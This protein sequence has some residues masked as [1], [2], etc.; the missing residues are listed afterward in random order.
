MET[1]KLK[2]LIEKAKQADRL[3]AGLFAQAVQA[4][5]AAFPDENF[6][7]AEHL[8]AEDPTEAVLHLVSEHL[9][10]WTISLKG[11]AQDVNGDWSCILRRSD[12][13]DNEVS[14]GVGSGRTLSLAVLCAVLR[15]SLL[16][17]GG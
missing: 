8:I 4:M 2:N 9:P 16:R 13:H 1:D 3:D 12:I 6:V 15:A 14:I 17:A 5:K 11:R 7:D 10:D